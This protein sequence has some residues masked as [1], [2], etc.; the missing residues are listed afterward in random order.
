MSPRA[1]PS[2]SRANCKF[3]FGEILDK[4]TKRAEPDSFFGFCAEQGRDTQSILGTSGA[5]KMLA[6]STPPARVTDAQRCAFSSADDA[7]HT[8]FPYRPKGNAS[9]R[10]S[11]F[12][13]DLSSSAAAENS[14]RGASTTAECGSRPHLRS[15]KVFIVK[16]EKKLFK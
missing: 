10:Y 16:R 2:S 7:C 4:E 6:S 5:S 12:R 11:R 8:R 9:L 1:E 15:S 3:F 13:K 14:P